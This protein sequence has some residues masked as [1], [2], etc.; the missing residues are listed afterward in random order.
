MKLL[1]ALLAVC[2]STPALAAGTVPYGSRTGMEVTVVKMSGLDSA[3]AKIVTKHTREN[4]ISFCRDYVQK[5][6]E[7]CIKEEMAVRLND[8]ISGNCKTGTFETFTGA[9]YRFVVLQKGNQ[10]AAY[11][12]IDLETNQPLDGS[13]ASGYPVAMSIYQALCPKTAPMDY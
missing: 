12:V 10:D 11:K 4:A 5:V 7:D 9:R 1:P 2:L 13:S 6:T 3:K 8:S